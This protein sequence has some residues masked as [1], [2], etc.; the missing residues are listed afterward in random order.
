MSDLTIATEIRNQIGHKALYMLGAKNI[1][2]DS[3]SLSFRIRGSQ[4]VNHIKIA[5]NSMDLYD[6]TFGKIRG[7]SYKVVSE[8]N[9]V[10]NDMLHGIIESETGLY[11]SL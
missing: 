4:K 11:T 1:A 7:D 2:G 3:N 9:G 5:L 8:K 6:M 10:Y